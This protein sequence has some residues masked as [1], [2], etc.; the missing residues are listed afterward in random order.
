M[1]KGIGTWRVDAIDEAVR[2]FV[3]AGGTVASAVQDVGEGIKVAKVA[4]PFGNII[5]LIEN[6]NFRLPTT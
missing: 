3:R 2:H 1:V 6:P 4:D 5:G